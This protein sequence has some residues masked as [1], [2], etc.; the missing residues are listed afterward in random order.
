MGWSARWTGAEAQRGTLMAKRMKNAKAI[1]S[2]LIC[3]MQKSKDEEEENISHINDAS[4][5]RF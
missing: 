3:A 4:T 2:M 1:G 5:Y